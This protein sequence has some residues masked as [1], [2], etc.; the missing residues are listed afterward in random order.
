MAWALRIDEMPNAD[1]NEEPRARLGH[2]RPS[3]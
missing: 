3:G 1:E 2:F